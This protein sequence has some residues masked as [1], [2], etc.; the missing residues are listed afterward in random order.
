M[1][2]ATRGT[3]TSFLF[4]SAQLPK[5]QVKP[6]AMGVQ[7]L[8]INQKTYNRTLAIAKDKQKNVHSAEVNISVRFHDYYERLKQIAFHG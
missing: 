5:E 3:D 2:F 8:I 1:Q 4:F 6:Y 7:N